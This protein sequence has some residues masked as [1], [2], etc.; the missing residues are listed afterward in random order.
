MMDIS[1]VGILRG[2]G[3]LSCSLVVCLE[4]EVLLFAYDEDTEFKTNHYQGLGH[5]SLL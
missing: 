3:V 2:C 4:R 5:S 1:F